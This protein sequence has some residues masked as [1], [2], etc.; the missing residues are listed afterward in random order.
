MPDEGK[1]KGPPSHPWAVGVLA[2]AA[3]GLVIGPMTASL[4]VLLILAIDRSQADVGPRAYWGAIVFV[5]VPAL[6]L[7]CFV[8][9]FAKNYTK[10]AVTVPASLAVLW[11]AVSAIFELPPLYHYGGGWPIP[12]RLELQRLDGMI[13]QWALET[14]QT[15]NTI[16]DPVELARFL[17]EKGYLCGEMPHCPS[18]GTYIFGKVSQRLACS[19]ATNAPPPGLK[20][21]TGLLGWRWRI[22]PSTSDA[23]ALAA[24]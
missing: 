9:L 23:H 2:R 18:G 15:T 20:E 10:W 3:A 14:K 16:V 21:R 17:R 24:E 13:Q 22:Q 8:R 11:V 5:S 6:A 12:C 7:F 4:A 1:L 19:L